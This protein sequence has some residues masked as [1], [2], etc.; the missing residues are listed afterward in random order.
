MLMD[1]RKLINITSSKRWAFIGVE[2]LSRVG[3]V[4]GVGS[5]QQRQLKPALSRRVMLFEYA[6]WNNSPLVKGSWPNSSGFGLSE[7]GK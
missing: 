3:V 2:Y 5:L 7:L 4:N 6:L 1:I